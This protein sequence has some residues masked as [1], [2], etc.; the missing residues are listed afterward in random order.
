VQLPASEPGVFAV[1]AGALEQIVT[2][3]HN[4]Q[5]T[6]DPERGVRGAGTSARA[7]NHPPGRDNG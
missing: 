1:G 5:L 7:A 4:P 3:L 2:V 6:G